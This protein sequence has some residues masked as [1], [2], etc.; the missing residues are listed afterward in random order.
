MAAVGTIVVAGGLLTSEAGADSYACPSM[1]GDVHAGFS[2]GAENNV[3][4]GFRSQPDRVRIDD[5]TDGFAPFTC[6]KN[7]P[8]TEVDV[9]LNDMDDS[10]RL[11]AKGLG[12]N[13]KALPKAIDAGL[14]GLTGRDSLRG[15]KG[16]DDADG[17]ERSDTI[18]TFGGA[19]DVAGGS[20]KDVIEAGS[21]N[22][23]IHAND[24]FVDRIDCG[25]GDDTVTADLTDKIA[26]N[27]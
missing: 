19:D 13:W 18:K 2:P 10:V 22:D 5:V 20:G 4:V 6:T 1:T 7:V 9:T 15:H 16:F 17:G 27:C 11:D 25:K 8:F 12:G 21:G 14:V 3:V 26:A 23:T 24:G